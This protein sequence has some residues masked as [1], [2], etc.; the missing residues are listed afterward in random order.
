MGGFRSWSSTVIGARDILVGFALTTVVV[1]VALAL[2]P[3]SGV[4]GTISKPLCKPGVVP[5]ECSIVS[6]SASIAVTQYTFSGIRPANLSWQSKSDGQGRFHIDSLPPG[7]YWLFA[8]TNDGY[9]AGTS[10]PVFDG[11]VTQIHL[12]L[13]RQISGGICLAAT[14][15]IATPAGFVPVSQVIPGMIVWT[16]DASGRQVAAPVLAVAHRPAVPGQQMLRLTLS[17]GRV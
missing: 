1:L 14:D 5:V 16:R 2:W 15:R 12:F 4:A 8:Q 11:Q 10:F 7:G 13:V 17:D 6:A 3:H 9:A